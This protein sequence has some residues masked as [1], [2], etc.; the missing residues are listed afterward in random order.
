MTAKRFLISCLICCLLF[1]FAACSNTQDTTHPQ[2]YDALCNTMGKPMD[3]ALEVLNASDAD[4]KLEFY[5]VYSVPVEIT[6]QKITFN[7]VSLGFSEDVLFSFGYNAVFNAD[8]N[9]KATGTSALALHLRQVMGKSKEEKTQDTDKQ[10]GLDKGEPTFEEVFSEEYL[11][12]WFSENS[13]DTMTYTWIVGDLTSESAK[14]LY[15]TML[16][17]ARHDKDYYHENLIL[18]ATLTVTKNESGS[19]TLSLSYKAY[20]ASKQQY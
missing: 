20:L 19:A 13:N 16:K 11:T 17:T 1:S 5:G 12:Q 18:Q 8:S 7:T 15:E 2:Y 9:N 3:A 14:S 10:M 6:F 4:A